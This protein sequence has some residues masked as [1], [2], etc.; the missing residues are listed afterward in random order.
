M[1]SHALN[2]QSISDKIG[3]RTYSSA[4][5]SLLENTTLKDKK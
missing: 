3:R 2:R 4:T 5:V 1:L